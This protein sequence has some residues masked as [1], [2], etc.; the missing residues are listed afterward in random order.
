MTDVPLVRPAL[1]AGELFHQAHQRPTLD[2]A[3]RGTVDNW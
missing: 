3:G 1:F 2:R